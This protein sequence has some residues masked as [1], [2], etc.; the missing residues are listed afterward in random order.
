MEATEKHTSP[1]YSSLEKPLVSGS[2]FSTMHWLHWLIILLSLVLTLTAWKITSNQIAE[3]AASSYQRETTK[4]IDLVLERMQR[5]EDA[6]W[7]SAA[8]INSIGGDISFEEWKVYAEAIGIEKK[9]PGINGIGII[10]YLASEDLQSYLAEQRKTRSKYAVHPPHDK[11][12]YWP[13][14]Y[15]IPLAGNEKAVGLDMAHESNRHSAA[16]LARDSGSAQITGPIELVQDEQHTPGFLFFAPFYGSH[17]IPQDTQERR[18]RFVGLVYA[19]FV[20]RN[21]VDGVLSRDFRNVTFSIHDAEEEI[22]NENAIGESEYDPNPLFQS[23]ASIE[24]YG[25][26][27]TFQF[28]SSKEFKSDTSSGQPTTILIGGITV[29]VLLL[30][31][32]LLISRNSRRN[33]LQARKLLQAQQ[34]IEQANEE[35][36]HFNYRT[37][38]DLVAPLKTIRGYVDLA[39][40]ELKDQNTAGISDCLSRIEKQAQRLEKLV[41][42]LLD[43]CRIDNQNVAADIVDPNEIFD[44]VSSTLQSLWQEKDVTVSLENKLGSPF[45]SQ[46]VRIRQILENLVSNGI[47]YSDPEKLTRWVKV[48]FVR[49]NK[50]W[51]RI[52]VA[53]NGIGIPGEDREK[54]FE[55]F[56]RA[57][58]NSEFGSGLGNYLVKKHVAALHGKIDYRSSDEGTC[59]TVDIPAGS[60]E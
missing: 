9:Y 15:I 56:F 45:R 55:M 44:F 13:I 2:L 54:I 1:S 4:I 30:V 25:R 46:P 3:K 22:F 16:R 49:V 36:T 52:E 40:Y 28:R 31:L 20:V 26:T 6:L 59:F 48:T 57:G 32:F 35:L 18:E 8:Y 29:D 7:A 27:W 19:P 21:L 60:R 53:D 41:E 38:H 11:T 23:S 33:A 10:H 51:I 50:D 12:E 5:Y 58:N 34:K 37:S 14:S 47:K 42:D 39:Q 43:L 24:L 17:Q